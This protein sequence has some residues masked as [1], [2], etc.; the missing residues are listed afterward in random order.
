MSNF[1]FR[2]YQN[3]IVRSHSESF[4]NIL[5]RLSLNSV[6]QANIGDFIAD[7]HFIKFSLIDKEKNADK[8]VVIIQNILPTI[9]F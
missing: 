3:N 4:R 2:V 7:P 8:Y 5:T 6:K 1:Y 9:F